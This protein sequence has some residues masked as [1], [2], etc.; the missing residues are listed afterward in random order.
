[1]KK[2]I[3]V[4]MMILMAATAMAVTED[5]TATLI[6][7]LSSHLTNP[8]ALEEIPGGFVIVDIEGSQ[9]FGYKMGTDGQL[10]NATSSSARVRWNMTTNVSTKIIGI[11]SFNQTNGESTMIVIDKTGN[12]LLR[13]NASDFQRHGATE[14][15]APSPGNFSS[16]DDVT[17]IC[18]NASHIWV[19]KKSGLVSTLNGTNSSTNLSGPQEFSALGTTSVGSMDCIGNSSFAYLDDEN[20]IVRISNRGLSQSVYELINLSSLTGIAINSFSDIAFNDIGNFYVIS[21]STKSIYR[22]TRKSGLER[23]VPGITFTYP[24]SRQA[25]GSYVDRQIIPFNMSAENTSSFKSADIM[26]CSVY[27]NGTLNISRTSINNISQN[28]TINISMLP[29]TYEAQVKCRA[30][31]SYSTTA[32]SGKNIFTVKQYRTLFFGNENFS[33]FY[34]DDINAI[35]A[36]IG[37]N[38][39]KLTAYHNITENQHVNLRVDFNNATGNRTIWINGQFSASDNGYHYDNERERKLYIGSANETGQAIAKISYLQISTKV[40]DHHFYNGNWLSSWSSSF[41]EF[42]GEP[43]TSYFF[44]LR[45][46]L[47]RTIST[48]QPYLSFM[49]VSTDNTLINESLATGYKSIA[50]KFAS[51][52]SSATPAGQ[53]ASVP[54]KV[55]C[56]RGNSTMEIAAFSR[57]EF[58]SCFNVR[59]YNQSNAGLGPGIINNTLNLSTELKT[60]NRALLP[61]V[62]SNVWINVTATSCPKTAVFFDLEFTTEP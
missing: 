44:Q 45:T 15:F 11:R 7:N 33:I 10:I 48:D 40:E 29:G 30:N 8:Q 51:A 32:T 24:Y 21:N 23:F 9:T 62:C 61:G 58:S 35:Q 18:T 4:I 36:K 34:N 50:F 17:G 52:S 57:T 31:S 37:Y 46:I 19:A 42:E 55:I 5:Y 39:T 16:S 1:M 56:N 54:I 27:I 22:I 12:R 13:I 41:R 59:L 49:N 53:E 20:A 60:F 14:W 26:N 3:I 25:I 2:A 38:D 47:R 43:G 28:T 6:S